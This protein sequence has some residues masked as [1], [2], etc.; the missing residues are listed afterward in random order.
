MIEFH[1]PE[2][3]DFEMPF[4]Q[5]TT[6]WIMN[7]ISHHGRKTGE[8]NFIFCSDEYLYELNRIHLQHDWYTDVL[9]F[10]LSDERSNEITGDIYISL[11]RVLENAQQFQAAEID[12]LHRV[13]IHGVLHLLGFDDSTESE[14]KE[15]RRLEDFMLNLR[16]F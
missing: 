4:V 10:D 2:E 16:M 5:E 14:S 3:L 12:E 8:I 9:T 7:V 13:M 1:N 11:T 15:M 6:D